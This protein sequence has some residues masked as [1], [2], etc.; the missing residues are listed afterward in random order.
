VTKSVA[1]HLFT[2]TDCEALVCLRGCS[3]DPDDELTMTL[4]PKS[5][6]ITVVHTGCGGTVRF[7]TDD[8]TVPA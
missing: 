1:F 8:S 7:K 5:G 2:D 6:R 3:L 4:E